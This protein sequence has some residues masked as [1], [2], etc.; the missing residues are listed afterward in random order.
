MLASPAGQRVAEPAAF[1]CDLFHLLA[2]LR[3]VR[4]AFA[5]DRLGI[6]TPSHGLQANQCQAVGK[7]AGPA[8]RDAMIPHRIERCLS[9]LLRCR[10]L[11]PSRSFRTTLSIVSQTNG[12][13]M[14]RSSIYLPAAASAWRSHPP[15]LSDVRPPTPPCRQTRAPLDGRR[16]LAVQEACYEAGALIRV[17]GANV[18]L[19]PP[20][21]MSEADAG[22]LLDAL[23]VGVG[24]A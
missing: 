21:V 11:F 6:D 13:P 1:A 3:M 10:Q 5:P 23:R 8:L 18:I 4:R 22:G 14:A 15:A 19:S 9:P 12:V 20:L 2:N 24:A 17:S 16:A 7:P